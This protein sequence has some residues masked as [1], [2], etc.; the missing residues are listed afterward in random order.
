MNAPLAPAREVQRS[1]GA[2]A[3][4]RK[5]TWPIEAEDGE[6]E[7]E[8]ADE[9]E[10]TGWLITVCIWQIRHGKLK[11]K[12]LSQLPF[13]SPSLSL[14]PS[15]W[16]MSNADHAC[17]L[18]W[19][20]QL[21]LRHS[22]IGRGYVPLVVA[23]TDA[24]ADAGPEIATHCPYNFNTIFE[25]IGYKSSL[26]CCCQGRVSYYTPLLPPTP[27]LCRCCATNCCCR[28]ATI[29]DTFCCC[30]YCRLCLTYDTIMCAS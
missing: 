2:C 9:P 22:S 19:P 24:D 14:S 5:L 4:E 30:R 7:E 13:N 16:A 25:I 23:A 28:A 8:A 15:L 12:L 21:Q 18:T 10:Q 1:A 26:H 29:V 27:S 17:C 20:L 3:W 11:L 6:E